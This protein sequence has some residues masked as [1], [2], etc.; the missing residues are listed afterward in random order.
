MLIFPAEL[1]ISK[2]ALVGLL[3][4]SDF[5]MIICA[6]INEFEEKIINQEE[7]EM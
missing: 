4:G 1:T 5:S 6:K 3:G 7:L 2:M